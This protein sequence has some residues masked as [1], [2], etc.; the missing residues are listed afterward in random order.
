MARRRKP[1]RKELRYD[2]NVRAAITAFTRMSAEER[3]LYY[4]DPDAWQA[5]R[6]A[7]A[8]S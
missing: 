2:A 6:L 7:A 1:T 5:Q 3:K 8:K 4:E